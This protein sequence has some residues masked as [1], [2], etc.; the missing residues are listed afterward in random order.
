MPMRVKINEIC[1]VCK[2]RC[3]SLTICM[4][5]I[6]AFL[7]R[8]ASLCGFSLVIGDIVDVVVDNGK[9]DDDKEDDV[10][11]KMLYFLLNI[12]VFAFTRRSTA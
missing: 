4:H 2:V 8:N 6:R 11:A 1:S 12:I 7:Q 3:A 9:D 10:D 5:C